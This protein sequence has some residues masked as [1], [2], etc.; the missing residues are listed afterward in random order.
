MLR[1]RPKKIGKRQKKKKKKKK[2]PQS[3]LLTAS[4]PTA[5]PFS[6]LLINRGHYLKCKDNFGTTVLP[7]WTCFNFSNILS[8]ILLPSLHTLHTRFSLPRK[9]Q[10]FIQM[11]P[12]WGGFSVSP[13]PRSSTVLHNASQSSPSISVN[14]YSTA[15]SINAAPC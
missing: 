1:E 4:S 13:H 15:V 5:S 3:S 9:V 7:Y 11:S 8:C 6:K 2:K 10:G 14:V 12:S